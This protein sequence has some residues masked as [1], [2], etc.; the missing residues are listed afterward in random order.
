MMTRCQ[1]HVLTEIIWF[2]W[3][4][5][6]YMVEISGDEQQTR[7]DKATQPNGCCMAEF[8]NAEISHAKIRVYTGVPVFIRATL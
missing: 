6:S 1:D 4:E 3:S 8:C 7:K 2:V 5:T